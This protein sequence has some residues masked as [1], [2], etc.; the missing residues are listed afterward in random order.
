MV[1]VSIPFCLEIGAETETFQGLVKKKTCV[2]GTEH[3][4][5][6]L[7]RQGWTKGRRKGGGVG[8]GA[9]DRMGDI[10]KGMS[11]NSHILAF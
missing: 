5:T 8:D 4:P 11:V 7:C 1:Q 2:P 3:C 9:P 10:E 6:F